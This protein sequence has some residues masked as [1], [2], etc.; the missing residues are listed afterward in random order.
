MAFSRENS[1]YVTSDTLCSVRCPAI[2]R[3]GPR[4]SSRLRLRVFFDFRHY[5]GGKV[6]T[7]THRPSLSPGVSK[8]SFL[9]AESTPGHIVPSVATEKIPHWHHWG[10][11]PRLSDWQRSAP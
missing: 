6:V 3:G 10:L 5:E 2:G 9:E 11:I 7:L 4:G 8:Y 1:C